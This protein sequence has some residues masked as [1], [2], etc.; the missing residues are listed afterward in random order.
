MKCPTCKDANIVISDRQGID[1]DYCPDCRGVWPD[2]RQIRQNN[3]TL[4][5]P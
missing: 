1:I 2:P 4:Q 5:G 3:R